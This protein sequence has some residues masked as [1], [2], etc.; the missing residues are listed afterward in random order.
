MQD[1]LDEIEETDM[2]AEILAGGIK[3]WQ[4]AYAG[5]LMDFYDEKAWEEKEE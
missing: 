1:Y 4:K 3:A 2:K 5:Q